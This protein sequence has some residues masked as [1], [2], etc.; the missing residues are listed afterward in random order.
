MRSGVGSVASHRHGKTRRWSKGTSHQR[1]VNVNGKSVPYAEQLFFAG[2]ASLS[3]L[4][5]IAAPIG[6]TAEGL[7]VALQIIGPEGVAVMAIVSLLT[8]AAKLSLVT[9]E[10]T[11]REGDANPSDSPR[12]Q[13][14]FEP[15]VPGLS[16]AGSRGSKG[17]AA[18][19]SACASAASRPG[20]KRK[21]RSR[22][23]GGER[24]A[25]ERSRRGG[26]AAR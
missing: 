4:P 10:C 19:I 11:P 14:G 6:L 23:S 24:S 16:S 25:L 13:A 2:L 22:A 26:R 21:I 7:P 12:E 5:A 15:S 9:A 17:A 1:T 8:S 18:A 3:Y 20:G